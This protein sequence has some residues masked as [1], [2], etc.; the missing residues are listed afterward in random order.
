MR[1]VHA[2]TANESQPTMCESCRSAMVVRTG[3]P[4]DDHIRCSAMGGPSGPRVV[5]YFV[6]SCSLYDDKRMPSRWDMEQIAWV[7]T[8]SPNR[9]VG[10]LS[11]QQA[12]ELR[13]AP[14]PIGP[15]PRSSR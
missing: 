10:F 15:P 11:P 14:L 12:A 6:S 1:K 9:K 13:N 5:R 7:L 3:R 4:S 8:T 2:G